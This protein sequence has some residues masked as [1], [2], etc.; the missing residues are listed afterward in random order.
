MKEYLNAL[1]Y[2]LNYGYKKEDRTGVGTIST[3]GLMMKFDLKEG[4]PAVT[5]KRL[6][7]KS[8]TSEL[9]WF[10]EGSTDE[11]RL[12]E[13]HYGKDR[14][15]LI[16]KKT[17][18]TEN[19]DFQGKNLGY[20]NT[21]TEKELGNVYGAQWI[22]WN[23]NTNQIDKLIKDL[24]TNPY[25]RRHILSAWNV[26][27]I[28]GM[29]LPP[30]HVMSQF[31][32][33]EMSF[34]DRLKYFKKKHNIFIKDNNIEK[35]EELLNSMNVPTKALSCMLTQRSADFFLGV[36]F[37]I[38]SYAILTHMLAHVCDMAVDTFVHSIGDAHIYLNHIEQ[39]KEQLSREPLS[40]PKL[41]LNENIKSI[42]DFKMNDINIIDYVSHPAIKAEMAV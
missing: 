10:L 28:D 2:I 38:A 8:V 30:C 20:T 34:N 29:A 17:I 41:H 1:E 12:A 36:P 31:Y 4:F 5:T 16:G 18:W 27:Q 32:V 19:A 37:N 35:V 9:L 40:L 25:S 6:L 13:I 24:K 21:D 33:K 11:R 42:Y 26:D 22:N 14:K 23:G 39:V 15:E 7:F 3:F